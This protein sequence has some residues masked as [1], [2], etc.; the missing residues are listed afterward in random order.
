MTSEAIRKLAEEIAGEMYGAEEKG[1]LE[2]GF[3]TDV[4]FVVRGIAA[5]LEIARDMYPLPCAAHEVILNQAREAIG[6]P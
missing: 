2:C 6:R 1:L 3:D 5:G 4:E